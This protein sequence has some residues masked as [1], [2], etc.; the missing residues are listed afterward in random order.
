MFP[1]FNIIYVFANFVCI[2]FFNRNSLIFYNLNF[3]F[4]LTKNEVA[5][6]HPFHCHLWNAHFDLDARHGNKRWKRR[7]LLQK[8]HEG[9]R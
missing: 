8:M 5:H 2:L 1:L 6:F 3:S 7:R 4:Q 9:I